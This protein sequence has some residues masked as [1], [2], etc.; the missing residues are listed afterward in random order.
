MSINTIPTRAACLL[1][2]ALFALGAPAIGEAQTGYW[3]Y[4]KTDS[5][6][7]LYANMGGNPPNLS[8]TYVGGEGAL[9]DTIGRASKRSVWRLLRLEPPPAI[10][11]PGTAL[12]WPAAAT[13]VQNT[14]K[15]HPISASFL[16]PTCTLPVGQRSFQLYPH[17]S[18]Y[19]IEISP[20]SGMS[21]GIP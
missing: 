15:T 10:L 16:P 13:I 4:V 11:I 7:D 6:I 14:G 19:L 17:S 9:T 1:L 12:Y 2:A 8:D 3:Q 20:D 18:P 21:S 5:Y